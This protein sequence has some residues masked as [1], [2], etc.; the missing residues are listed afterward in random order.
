M[1]VVAVVVEV[2]LTDLSVVLVVVV[3]VVE[4]ALGCVDGGVESP[5]PLQQRVNRSR[6]SR[7]I[8]R[9]GS[10]YSRCSFS[11]IVK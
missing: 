1:V 2:A 3:V 7:Q 6:R 10:L 9:T 5:A 8:L 4:V 11:M